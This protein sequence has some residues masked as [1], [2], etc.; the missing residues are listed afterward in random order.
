MDDGQQTRD[1]NH[2]AHEPA[3]AEIVAP[4]EPLP[5]APDGEAPDLAE[6][7]SGDGPGQSP[8]E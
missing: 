5:S 7:E 1:S 8:G 4:R 3:A 6:V 2:P